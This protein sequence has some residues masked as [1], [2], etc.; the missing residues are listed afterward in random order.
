MWVGFWIFRSDVTLIFEIWLGLGRF[1]WDVGDV[2]GFLEMLFGFWK[3]CLDFCDF[4]LIFDI[5]LGIERFYWDL[6][7]L[8]GVWEIWLGFGKCVSY[9]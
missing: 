8:P 9:F 3:C 5:W 7:N 4:A 6:G 1:C 2:T